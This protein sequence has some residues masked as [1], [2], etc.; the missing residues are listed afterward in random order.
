MHK[1][2]GGGGVGRVDK[3]VYLRVQTG[4]K[5]LSRQDDQAQQA[6]TKYSG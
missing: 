6:N 1:R 4:S 5:T 3:M 2:K